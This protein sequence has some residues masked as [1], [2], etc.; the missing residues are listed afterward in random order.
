MSDTAQRITER[1][2]P[3]TYADYRS[4]EP[5][6]GE[7][8]ELIYGKAYAMPAPNDQHQATGRGNQ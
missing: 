7:R 3:Y 8:F 1:D 2:R 6:E 4:R 5:E